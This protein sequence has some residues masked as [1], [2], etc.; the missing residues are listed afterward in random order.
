MFFLRKCFR[1][2]GRLGFAR[3]INDPPPPPPSPGPLLTTRHHLGG[4]GGGWHKGLGGWL[5]ACGG[6]CPGGGGGDPE[7]NFCPGGGGGH[8]PKAHRKRAPVPPG[9]GGLAQGL[10]GWLLACGGAYWP[11]AF[12]PSAHFGGGGGVS[13][14]PIDP[15]AP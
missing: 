5:L 8:I 13:P 12:E 6:A 11:L 9:G 15:H 10:G 7:W 4:G 3:I 2:A 14:A 1:W